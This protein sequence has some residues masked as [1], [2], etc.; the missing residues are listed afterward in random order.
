MYNELLLNYTTTSDFRTVPVRYPQLT[1]RGIPRTDG[2]AGTANFVLGTEASSQGNTLDQRTF[3]ITDNFTIP[4]GSHSFTLGA[5]D[6]F[7]KPINLFAQNSLGSW[8]FNDLASLSNGVASSYSVSAPA[9]TDPAHGLATFHASMLALY[10]QDDWQVTPH[11]AVTAGVRYDVPNFSDTPPT[12]PS[13]H[14][15]VQ[16]QH[17]ERA[18]QRRSSRRASPSTGTSRATRRTSFAVASASSR[19]RRRSCTCRTRS[20]TRVSP[21]LR[22]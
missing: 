15:R 9:A 6:Q 16:S 11:L 2:L 5:K 22:R 7:Y 1:I 4:M 14:H 12:N 21:A 13:V 19:V 20:A 3:E 18:G 8:T 10:A 17:G